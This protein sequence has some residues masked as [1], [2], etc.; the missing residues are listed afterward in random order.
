MATAPITRLTC[1]KKIFYSNLMYNVQVY[2]VCIRTFVNLIW[3]LYC[4]FAW[5]F[6]FSS[7]FSLKYFKW[8]WIIIIK[9]GANLILLVMDQVD[10]WK[11]L[12]KKNN[13]SILH[14]SSSSSCCKVAKHSSRKT[15]HFLQIF[16]YGSSYSFLSRHCGRIS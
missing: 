13:L 16:L 6:Y 15:A 14:S 7:F 11:R 1:A 8:L 3:Q 2:T 10:S 9:L 5:I 12:E 4:L